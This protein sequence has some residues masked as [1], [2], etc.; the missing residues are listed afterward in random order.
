MSSF[1]WFS[2][3]PS[4]DELR[5][6]EIEILEQPLEVV[7]AVVAHRAGLDVL[8]DGGEVFQNE[9]VRLLRTLFRKAMKQLGRFQ[10]V[11]QPP[12]GFLMDGGEHFLA[13]RRGFV[14]LVE[15]DAV[16]LQDFIREEVHP[17]GQILVKD[18]AQDVVP[19]LIRPHLPAQSVG[20]VP[21]L[22]LERLSGVVGH[23]NEQMLIR[24]KNGAVVA[25]LGQ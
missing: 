7:L 17:L 3:F 16:V 19:K 9:I 23:G 5:R 24:V 22:S 20:D 2:V 1:F 4:F 10:E 11:P 8:Q 18:E 15:P 13:I 12:D 14:D 21:E 6:A 25:C